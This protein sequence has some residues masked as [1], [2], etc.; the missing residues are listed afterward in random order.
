MIL[1]LSFICFED[2]ALWPTNALAGDSMILRRVVREPSLFKWVW[3]VKNLGVE[4]V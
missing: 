2:N 3:Q 1:L 4:V